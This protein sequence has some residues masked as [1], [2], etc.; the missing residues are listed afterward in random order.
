MRVCGGME[1]QVGARDGSSRVQWHDVRPHARGSQSARLGE[2]EL[3][4]R[5]PLRE[6]YQRECGSRKTRTAPQKLQ[7]PHSAVAVRAAAFS[8]TRA[9]GDV[10][11]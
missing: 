7:Q 9:R 4:G 11:E 2:A 5:T 3:Q 10:G 8:I 1:E 6:D